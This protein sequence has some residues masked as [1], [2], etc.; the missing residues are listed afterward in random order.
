MTAKKKVGRGATAA[1]TAR[2]RFPVVG[3]GASAGGLEAF[4]QLLQHLPLDTGMGFVL[5]QHLD[6]AH[7]SALAHLLSR[8]TEMPVHEAVSNQRVM[9]NHVYVIAPNT[10][11]RIAKGTLKSQARE[12]PYGVQ[13]A[14]DVFLESLAQDLREQAI[15][16][17]LSGNAS[18]GTLGLEAIKANGGIT[19]VQDDSAQY[20]SMPH[21]AIAAGCV[22]FVFAPQNIAQELARVARHPYV[23][24]GDYMAAEHPM[25]ARVDETLGVPAGD[26][27]QRAALTDARA[28]PGKTAAQDLSTILRLVRHHSDVD[29]SLYKSATIERRIARRM[30]LSRMSTPQAYA[31]LLRGNA[32]EVDL[33]YADML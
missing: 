13:Y 29:F 12:H 33:L 26:P 2:G 23:A 6:P 30:V 31:R 25:R 17:I 11:L 28:A 1:R 18:D 3:I 20:R 22:D 10:V 21:S 14:I 19:L 15:G 9:P 32:R 8:A 16:V 24:V 27:D 4:T 7:P 5:V